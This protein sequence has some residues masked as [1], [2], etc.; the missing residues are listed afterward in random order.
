M[1]VQMTKVIENGS[2]R[3]DE[4]LGGE[5][6]MALLTVR[7]KGWSQ[8]A[9]RYVPGPQILVVRQHYSLTRGI[10]EDLTWR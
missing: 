2:S 3:W 1:E 8:G 6:W 10:L 5:E 7:G 4:Y 9:P